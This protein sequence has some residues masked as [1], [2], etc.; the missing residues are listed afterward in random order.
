MCIR[1]RMVQ[2][3]IRWSTSSC[4]PIHQVLRLTA[5][6]KLT[7]YSPRPVDI[8]VAVMCCLLMVRSC[9]LRTVAR[10]VIQVRNRRC[11]SKT[12]A[13]DESLVPMGFG[14]QWAPGLAPNGSTKHPKITILSKELP[15][16]HSHFDLCQTKHRRSDAAVFCL[17]DLERNT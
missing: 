3:D 17:M 10:Q 6:L 2:A 13:E 8:R 11:L 4:R 9:S 14:E 16:P 12:A 15:N 5:L 1:D 7:G